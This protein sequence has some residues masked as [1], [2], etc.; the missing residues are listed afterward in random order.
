MTILIIGSIFK[1]SLITDFRKKDLES[2]IELLITSGIIYRVVKTSAQEI[3]LGSQISINNF[4]L[5]FLDIA[6]SQFILDFKIGDLLIN[7]L[8][9]FIN[10]GLFIESFVGQEI[11]SKTFY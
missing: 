1:Y 9:E 4:K 11:I 5:I 6:L 8:N 3:T 7:P 2:C 10:K